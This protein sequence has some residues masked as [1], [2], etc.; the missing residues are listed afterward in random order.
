[1]N[2]SYHHVLKSSQWR[3][4]RMR[5]RLMHQTSQPRRSVVSLPPPVFVIFSILSVQLGAALAKS[6]FHEI[7]SGGTVFL[8]VGVA[9]IALLLMWR[10]HLQEYTRAHYALV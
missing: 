3:F 9:A 2:D 7:G 10:P 8:R 5:E 6:L 4:M 1:M